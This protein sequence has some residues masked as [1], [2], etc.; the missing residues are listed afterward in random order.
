MLN[1]LCDG[2][3]SVR[4]DS[5]RPLAISEFAESEDTIAIAF[6]GMTYPAAKLSKTFLPCHG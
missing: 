6:G 1:F 2:F 5:E 3:V 4:I